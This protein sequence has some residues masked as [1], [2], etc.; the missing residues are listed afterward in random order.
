MALQ[1][2]GMFGTPLA[3]NVPGFV[4]IVLRLSAFVCVC[5]CLSSSRRLSALLYVSC[6]IK[7]KDVPT[8]L[9]T[10]DVN[11]KHSSASLIMVCQRICSS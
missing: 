8:N 9:I 4:W 6:N 1:P 10:W 2:Y 3:S 5:L 7:C 11:V